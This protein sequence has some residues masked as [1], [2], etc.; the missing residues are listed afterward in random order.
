MIRNNPIMWYFVHSGLFPRTFN[1]CRSGNK[2]LQFSCIITKSCPASHAALITCHFKRKNTQ[3]AYLAKKK[4]WGGQWIWV[5][6][7]TS[8]RDPCLTI[9]ALNWLLAHITS[10]CHWRS[11]DC[12]KVFVFFLVYLTHFL[13]FLSRNNNNFIWT[14]CKAKEGHLPARWNRKQKWVLAS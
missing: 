1:R 13:W 7:K 8:P 12:E 14:L 9:G 11:R 5:F 6:N 2:R 3:K 4:G 10:S